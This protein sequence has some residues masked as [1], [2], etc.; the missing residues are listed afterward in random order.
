MKRT[1]LVRPTA[2]SNPA[3][4]IY[5]PRESSINLSTALIDNPNM[6][7]DCEQPGQ[8]CTSS[9][10]EIGTD[11]ESSNA[12]GSIMADVLTAGR[13]NP[14]IE[15]EETSSLSTEPP[16][17]N[18]GKPE[19]VKVSSCSM[20]KEYFA[21][22]DPVELLRRYATIAL[23]EDQISSV[24]RVVA[25]ETARALYDMFENLVYRASRLS[26]GAHVPGKRVP[27]QSSVRRLSQRSLGGES[28]TEASSETSGAIRSDDGFTS[29]CYSYEHSELEGVASPPDG[30]PTTECGPSDRASHQAG[31]TVCSPGS[32][33]LA[34]LR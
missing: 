30:L 2:T 19:P 32:Q 18:V 27:K 24:L 10:F 22:S 26:L 23:T 8:L 16:P 15:V 13:Y 5:S 28:E 6:G 21:K 33:I 29:I 4:Q 9:D 12:G 25:D 20:L 1:E 31:T 7:G 34:A 14:M 17:R 3:L 11:A